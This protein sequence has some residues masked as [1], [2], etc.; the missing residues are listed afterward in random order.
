MIRSVFGLLLFWRRRTEAGGPPGASRS[1]FLTV[2]FFLLGL[3]ALAT[4]LAILL[5]YQPRWFAQ[6]SPPPGPQRLKYSHEF[7]AEFCELFNNL[8][9]NPYARFTDL[10]INSY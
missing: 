8:D 4:V 6:A 9:D 2:G 10:Q 1:F 3:G 5:R 7:Y